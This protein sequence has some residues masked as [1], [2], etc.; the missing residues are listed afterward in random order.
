MSDGTIPRWALEAWRAGT[1]VD[2][3]H[4]APG[5]R[6]VTGDRS[7]WGF[8]HETWLLSGSGRRLVVQRRSDR[9]DPTR[10]RSRRVREAA[11]ATGLQVPEP[12]LAGH[13]AGHVVVALPFVD[14]RPGSELLTGEAGAASVGDLCGGIAARL[15]RVDAGRLGLPSAWASGA[16]LGRAAERWRHRVEG[17]LDARAA[18]RLGHVVRLA[19]LEAGEGSAVFAHGDLAPVNLLVDGGAVTAVLDFDRARLAPPMFDAAWFGWVVGHHHP[20]VA[21]AAWRGY[22]TA[23]GLPASWPEAFDWLQPLQL[24]ERAAG[25]PR[26]AERTIWVERLRAALDGR[27]L[28]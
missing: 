24:L 16:R 21:D 23:A 26:V 28:P 1:D 9:S 6:A 12:T 19:E 22:A 17:M 20:E 14:G 27:E 4:V 3:G 8:D 2:A 18:A 11:R 25:A 5:D 7:A 13:D 10:P 15:A